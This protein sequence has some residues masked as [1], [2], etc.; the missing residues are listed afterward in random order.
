MTDYR[1][2]TLLPSMQLQALHFMAPEPPWRL[3]SWSRIWPPTFWQQYSFPQTDFS[4]NPPPAPESQKFV[5]G[6]ITPFKIHF[7]HSAHHTICRIQFE[8]SSSFHTHKKKFHHSKSY[9]APDQEH[10]LL[11]IVK[12]T[13][14]SCTSHLLSHTWAFFPPYGELLHAWAPPPSYSAAELKLQPDRV[15]LHLSSGALAP[16]TIFHFFPPPKLLLSLLA[17]HGRACIWQPEAGLLFS[18]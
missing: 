7:H 12:L 18:N 1:N 16:P 10:L 2:R 14:N 11:L 3:P 6:C 9:L 8:I 17:T 15:A 13:S 4:S 5:T